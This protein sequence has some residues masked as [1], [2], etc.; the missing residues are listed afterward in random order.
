MEGGQ[1]T[2]W[3]ELAGSKPYPAIGHFP[4]ID[5]DGEDSMAL[6]LHLGARPPTPIFLTSATLGLSPAKSSPE[7]AGRRRE[8]GAGEQEATIRHQEAQIQELDAAN[9]DLARTI[10]ALEVGAPALQLLH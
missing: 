9:T 4:L 5:D 3:E 1:R 6:S 2:L 8:S 10:R 7:R